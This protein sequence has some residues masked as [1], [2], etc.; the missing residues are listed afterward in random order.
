V[1]RVLS[2]NR[3][4]YGPFTRRFERAFAAAHGAR[5]A[6]FMNS[7][8]DALRI[9]LAAMKRRYGWRVGDEV[10]VPAVTFVA[11]ANIVIQNQMKP[12]F[13]DVDRR[14]YNIDPSKIEEKLTRRTRAV[15]PVHLMGLP[16]DMDPIWDLARRHRLKILEDSCEAMFATY[17]GKKV[18]SLGDAAA[19]ST[20]VAHFLVTGVGGIATTNN[21]ALA[22]DIRSLM[23]HGRDPIYLSIDDDQDVSEKKLARIVRGRFRFVA[24]GYSSRCTEMEAALGLAQLE[25]R[26]RIIRGRRR[27]AERYNR[28]LAE[29]DDRLQLP[30]DT[31]ASRHMYMLYPLVL[32]RENKWGL[33]YHLEKNGIE[34]RDLMPLLRAPLYRKLY[35]NPE[36]RYPVAR[37]INR[38]GF[39]I[40]CHHDLTLRQQDYVI[41]KIRAYFRKH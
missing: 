38:S 19:F 1:N 5:Y 8:T 39:Y 14:T 2:S 12:V 17:R 16:C 20:Y 40:G 26:E 24:L 7:G 29:F 25:E 27:V 6:S 37:W 18:G 3:L 36:K 31:D 9:A 15:I 28:A 10:L 33:V 22:V 21:R 13:V 41:G 23:N 35:G 11:T 4:S 30:T 34:T 32:R